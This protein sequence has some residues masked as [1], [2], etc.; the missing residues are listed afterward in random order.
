MLSFFGTLE[1][2]DWGLRS[3]IK[4]FDSDYWVLTANGGRILRDFSI[5]C[6]TRLALCRITK[7]LRLAFGILGRSSFLICEFLFLFG[8]ASPAL[9]WLFVLTRGC[10]VDLHVFRSIEP[11]AI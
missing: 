7:K 6:L 11:L 10:S 4:H 9:P 1:T 2:T 5:I 8:L 3:W